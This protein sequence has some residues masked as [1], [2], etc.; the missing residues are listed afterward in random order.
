MEMIIGLRIVVDT[1]GM[2]PIVINRFMLLQLIKSHGI[3]YNGMI[4]E[5]NGDLIIKIIHGIMD[6]IGLVGL[7]IQK[8]L[9]KII[10][11]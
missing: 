8:V 1:N 10:I 9:L 4:K 6:L 2:C 11:L 7:L 5:M 3:I